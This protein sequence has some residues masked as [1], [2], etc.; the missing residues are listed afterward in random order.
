MQRLPRPDRAHRYRVERSVFLSQLLV[1]SATLLLVA[2]SGLLGPHILTNQLFLAGILIVFV[3]TGVAAGVPWRH[4]DKKWIV[5][6]PIVDLVALVI[7]REGEPLL[8]TT[9]LLV[10]PI[11]W[12]SSHFGGRGAVG[13]VVLTAVLLWSAGLLRAE[14]I[15]GNE[16]PRLAIVPIVLAFVAATTYTTTKR[17]AAQR[18]LLT[19]QSVLFAGALRR[20]RREERTL[21]EIFNT[22]D[23]GV[24]GFSREAKPNFINRA[25]RE[26]FSRF[27]VKDGQF[28]SI[29]VFHDDQITPYAEAD[30]PFQRAMRGETVDHVTVWV[31]EKGKQQAAVLISARP[32]LDENDNYDGGVMVARDV[33]AELRAIKA[34]DDLVAS[35]SHEL[36]TPLT[37]IMGYLELA[38]DDDTLDPS[39]RRM[40]EV[41]SK[42]SDRLLALVADLLTTAAATKHELAITLAPCDLSVIV[43]EAIESLRPMA[44]ERDITFVLAALPTVRLQADAF[45]LRQV[46]D[47]LF[48]NA[49]KYNT[50]SGHI[51][52]TL[53]DSVS[54][55]ELRVAD[56]GRG[57]TPGEQ[58]NLFD[59]FYRADSVRGSSIHGTGLG[60][61]ISR[62]IC[63]QHGG[64]L[65]VESAPGKGTIAIA[66]LPRD[67]ER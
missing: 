2:V 64:D 65:R 14:P 23:F 25:Q 10:F 18:V 34:R 15:S 47:N 9:F 4:V 16:I 11:I 13:G 38:L 67:Y 30:R 20:S 29:V 17:A 49:V 35:V 62:D 53:I 44:A 41:A 42:N 56:T 50:K 22:I 37:S 51:E 39:T 27:G 32:I 31:G 40:L 21:D 24:V 3:T 61:S 45:R 36:R 1:G 6:L 52:V 63:R 19:Q 59:R 60:L 46:I 26:M 43:T 55:V 58:L 66:T 8:G 7:A 48:S 12:L 54:Q 5:I 33:T 28:S 57:M